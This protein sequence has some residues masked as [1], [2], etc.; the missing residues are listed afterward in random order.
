MAHNLPLRM[1][2]LSNSMF[3]FATALLGP[4][5][6][7]Y[8]E[9]ISQGVLAV[10]LTWSVFLCSSVLFTL[11]LS[12]IGDRLGHKRR[13]LMAG[14]LLRAIGWGL[15]IFATSLWWVIIVQI[16][17]GLGDALG[18]P[19]FDAMVAEH[20]DSG[21]HI[22]EYADWKLLSS[23]AMT[24]GTLIGGFVVY[25]LGFGWLFGTMSILAIAAW[26]MLQLS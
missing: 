6:A 22:Q 14:F 3:V 26:G 21:K 9:G 4:L 25:S 15:L 17:L 19:S 11:I 16:I 13:L 12:R 18:G 20:L 7:V 23:I 24:G 1:L 2:F 5:Y 10:S 8:L